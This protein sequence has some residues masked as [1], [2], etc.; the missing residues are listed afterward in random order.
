MG[1]GPWSHKESHDRAT[2]TYTHT[3]TR[4]EQLFTTHVLGPV[5]CPGSP[6][7]RRTCSASLGVPRSRLA[8]VLLDLGGVLCQGLV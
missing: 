1:C 7:S 5:L 6:E 3:H 2:N 8:W 4:S